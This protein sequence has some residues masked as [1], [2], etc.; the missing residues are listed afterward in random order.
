MKYKEFYNDILKESATPE[1]KKLGGDEWLELRETETPTGPYTYSHEIRCDGKIISILPY[2]RAGR[3]AYEIGI[4]EEIT[5]CW[6]EERSLSSVTGGVD[7]GEE[8]KA[9]AKRE[10]FEETGYDVDVS[11]IKELGTCRGTKSSDTVY[12]LFGVDLTDAESPSK[13]K[14]DGTENDLAPLRW[15]YIGD[16]IIDPLVYVSYHRLGL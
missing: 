11:K 1:S 13:P 9:A 4:R 15:M 12:Y 10:L 14:G 16:D 2:R 8:P 7:K 5:P 3:D 6:G